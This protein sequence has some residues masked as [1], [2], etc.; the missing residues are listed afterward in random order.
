MSP[1]ILFIITGGI[2]AYKA[3]EVMRLLN[4]QGVRSRCI[5][6]RAAQ[7][8]VT[9]LSVAA[10][11]GDTVYTD[12][13]SLTDEI[14]IGHIA[15][16]RQA[17]LIFVCPASAD[18]IARTAHGLADDLATTVLL[19]TDRPVVM[20]PAM[21]VKMW[22]HPATCANLA[23]LQQRGVAIIPPVTGSMAC[24]DYGPGRLLEPEALVA[25]LLPHLPPGGSQA[26]SAAASA[27]QPLPL[28]GKTALVTAGATWEPLDPVRFLG[29]RSSGLQGYAIAAA[30][31]Q[32]GATVTLVSGH[33][34][35]PPPPPGVQVIHAPT[36]TEML[37]A[38]LASLP[39]DIAV[40][41]AAVADWQVAKP[42]VH[43]QK[44]QPDQQQL[45]LTLVRTPDTLATLAHSPQR[46]RLLIGFAA[47]TH[48][49]ATH[50][51]AKRLA[52]GCDWIVGN[53]VSADNP[54]FGNA[55]N[56]V[57]LFSASGQE[58]WPSLHKTEVARRLVARMVDFWGEVGK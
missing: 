5:L 15:L 46:P 35:A 24:G 50:A 28:A 12:M 55:Y 8:F 23:T 2:A 56:Q 57:S 32:A 45:T 7:Q 37:A 52:K 19:A 21:N 3:L 13:F 25:A 44:K 14:E 58:D 26:D 4:R 31:H 17:D 20:A 10:L 18:F 9:P 29:N 36:A 39:V 30:L 34:T 6:T 27:L 49:L 48:D 16:S 47:E 41:A 54:A 1:R 33:T 53:L 43:K 40:C 11:S 22:Q 38:C 42:A 51:S